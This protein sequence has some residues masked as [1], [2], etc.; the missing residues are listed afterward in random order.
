MR[1]TM[2]ITSVDRRI[3]KVFMQAAL[4]R[5]KAVGTRCGYAIPKIQKGI[6]SGR[7]TSLPFSIS[8]GT[9]GRGVVPIPMHPFGIF[10]GTMCDRLSRN[11]NWHRA[12][13]AWFRSPYRVDHRVS[14]GADMARFV[15]RL[16]HTLEF[17][18]LTAL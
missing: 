13:R 18:D 11:L 3:S 8:L 4:V 14:N 16:K 1:L 15:H 12:T 5:Q 6:I 7:C 17:E 10:I 2:L 9:D